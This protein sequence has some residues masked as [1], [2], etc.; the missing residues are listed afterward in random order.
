M[1]LQQFFNSKGLPTVNSDFYESEQWQKAKIMCFFLPLKN[2]RPNWSLSC[3]IFSWALKFFIMTNATR[4]K[5]G[6]IM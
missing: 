3:V 4:F 5:W 6:K 1:I 2:E